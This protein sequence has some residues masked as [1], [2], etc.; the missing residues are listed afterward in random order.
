MRNLLACGGERVFFKDLD[1]RFLLVS[2]GWL[3][4]YG[5]GRSLEDVLG[6]T[7][8]DIFSGPHAAAAFEDE[9]RIM[10]T[11]EAVVGKTQRETFHGR[12]DAWSST[13]KMQIG[14]A[15]V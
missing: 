13:T 15:H 4:A 7:D 12:P 3:V 10:Q 14:R 5:Q 9:Q 6:K 2:E 1:S 11:G 8:F